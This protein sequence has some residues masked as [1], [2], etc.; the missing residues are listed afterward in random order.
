MNSKNKC[1][2]SNEFV[3]VV[4]KRSNKRQKSAKNI[5]K[6]AKRD[7]NVARKHTNPESK[8]NKKTTASRLHN[9]SSPGL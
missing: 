8:C 7:K 3:L 4:G 9:G 5:E 2:S 1:K 6:N